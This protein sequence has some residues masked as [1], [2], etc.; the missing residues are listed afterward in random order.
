MVEHKINH[1]VILL[2]FFVPPLFRNTV[3]F[4]S[5]GHFMFEFVWLRLQWDPTHR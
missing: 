2:P 5:Y 4:L 1:L 3:R